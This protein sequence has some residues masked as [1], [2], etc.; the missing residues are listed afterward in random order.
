MEETYFETIQRLA[1]LPV[2]EYE[3][4][5]RSEAKRLDMRAS[6][7]DKEVKSARPKDDEGN[8]LGL[9]EPD[10]WPEEVDSDDLLSRLV[11]GLRRHVVMPTYAA[12]AVALWVIHCHCFENWQHTPRLDVNAPEKEC[13]KSTLLRVIAGLEQLSAG[14][15]YIGDRPIHRTPAAKRGLAMVFQ[16][17]ALYPHKTVAQNMG[18]ALKMAKVSREE[19]DRRVREAARILQIEDLLER[20]PRQLSGGQRQRVAIGRAIVR[21]PKVFLFDEPLSNLDGRQL[22]ESGNDSQKRGLAGS[23][24]G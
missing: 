10:P 17:Y 21:E 12:V 16:N 8:D 6:V 9:F 14:E 3:R 11:E 7:L 23:V 20:K 2:N 5:R 19:I 24:K 18:F 13:G 4:A 1:A 15:I 22:L